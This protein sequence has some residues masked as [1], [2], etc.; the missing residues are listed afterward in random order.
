VP[1]FDAS[2]IGGDLDYDFSELGQP[3]VKG[4]IPEPSRF[5]VKRFF[6][7]VQGAFKELRVVD[8]DAPDQASPDSIVT[9]MNAI[10]DEELFDKLTEKITE[11]IAELC[12]GER[13]EDGN[14]SGG[15]PTYQQ[16]AA[17]KYRHFMVFFGYIMEN[18]MNPELSRPA[19]NR[20]QVRLTSV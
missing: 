5:A 10:D 7:N 14:W 11:N 17:L 18:L 15:S 20:S 2:S 9:T 12:G 6:K 1:K 4:S 3:D 13:D 8:K 19:T 16:I